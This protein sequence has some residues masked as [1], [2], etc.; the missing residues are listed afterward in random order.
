M[1]RLIKQGSD[2]LNSGTAHAVGVG[3]VSGN[4]IFFDYVSLWIQVASAIYIP[5]VAVIAII[6]LY[7]IYKNWRK[8]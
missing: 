2:M 5:V 6:R 1:D 4:I 8:K 7:G 3:A